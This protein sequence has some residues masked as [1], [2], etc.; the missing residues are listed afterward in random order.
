MMNNDTRIG[1]GLLVLASG[2]LVGCGSSSP[3]TP[4]PVPPTGLG[5][6]EL[7]T[8]RPDRATLVVNPCPGEGTPIPCTGDLQMT[9]SVV[10]NRDIDRARVWTEFYS[11]TGQ[12]CGGASTAFVSLTA[13]TPVTLTASSIYLSQG[14]AT[15]QCELPAQTTRMVAHLLDWAGPRDVLTQEFSNTY[16]FT[17]HP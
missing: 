3:S 1:L 9:F 13:G 15:S 2:L 10:Q 11:A 7:T 14:G 6:I 17:G 8:N 12:L 5:R 16:T 4:S